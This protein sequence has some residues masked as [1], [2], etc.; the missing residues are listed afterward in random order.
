MLGEGL[1][2]VVVPG[3]DGLLGLGG[4]GGATADAG[5]GPQVVDEIAAE[6]NEMG[7]VLVGAPDVGFEDLLGVNEDGA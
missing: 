1:E 4:P 6:A 7:F 5:D 3:G 2:V